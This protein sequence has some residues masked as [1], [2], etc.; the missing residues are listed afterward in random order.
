MRSFWSGKRVLVTGHT[1][2]KGSWLSTWLVQL[3]AKVFGYSLD[4]DTASS[5]FCQLNLASHVD[6]F[7]ADIRNAE[8]I[9]ARV[10]EVNPDVV[11]HL[12][13]QPLVRRSY[14]EASYTWQ[15]NVMGTV[16][17]LEALRNMRSRCSA[18]FVTT[19]KVYENREWLY[20]YRESDPL[21]G[22]DPYSSS[23][24]AAEIAVSSWRDSFFPSGGLVFP[25]VRVATARAGNVIGGGDWAEDRIVPDL[26]RSLAKGTVVQVRNPQSV[27]PWQHVLDPLSGYLRLAQRMHET[28]EQELQS[29]FNFGPGAESSRTVRDLVTE[30]LRHWEGQWVDASERNAVH[31][32]GLLGLTIEKA[33]SVLQWQPTLDFSDSV[34]QTI[35]WYRSVHEGAHAIDIT[36][37][38]IQA[39]QKR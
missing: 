7:V 29:C 19:D 37:Q 28:E 33:R 25:A 35:E 15:T 8:L 32:A 38:Q 3:G 1:G 13:A 39:F 22:Y 27:R 12:A 30:S 18:V 11:F 10:G 24:A 23:K 9:G 5:L 6:H 34:R 17:L 14:R 16:N 31:E 21:G 4:P 26:V 2:F 36:R 20:A